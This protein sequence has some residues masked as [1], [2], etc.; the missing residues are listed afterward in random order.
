MEFTFFPLVVILE[1]DVTLMLSL[2][3]RSHFQRFNSKAKLS[4]LA[5]MVEEEKY[6]QMS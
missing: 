5:I 6:M 1:M 4:P 2:E 3:T